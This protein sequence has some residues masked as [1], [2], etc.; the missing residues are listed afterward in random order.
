MHELFDLSNTVAILTGGTRGIG[1]ATARTLAELGAQVVISSEDATACQTVESELQSRDLKVLGV[2]CDVRECDQLERLVNFTLERFGRIDT[3]V[4]C[5][6]VAPHL[7]PI[8]SATDDDWNLTMTVNLQSALWLSSLVTPHM[9]G[10][11]SIVFVS[12]IA[13]L[14]GNKGIGLYGISKAGLA[15]LARNLAVEHG[16]KGIRVNVVSPGLIR[17]DFAKGM[18]ENPDIMGRRISLTPLRRVGE[19]HEIAGVIAMLASKAG[20]FISGQNLIV[21]GGTIISDGN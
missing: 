18:L 9:Q 11:G 14:R 5:A 6:G 19:A 16:P 7:G 12:S 3:L 17:T 4:C 1:L 2:S 15:Q 13:G 20:A 8:S 21:D 10:G